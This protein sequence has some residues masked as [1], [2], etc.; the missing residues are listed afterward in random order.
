MPDTAPPIAAL[1]ALIASGEVDPATVM[2]EAQKNADKHPGNGNTYLHRDSA[3]AIREALALPAKFPEA[4]DRPPLYGI[5]V[6]VKDCFDIIGTVATCGSKFYEAHNPP[7]L[8]NAW[9]VDRLLAAGAVITGKTH[10]H[11][12]AYG[13]TGENPEYGDCL[14][15]RDPSLLTGG[16]SSGAVASVQEGSA[17]FA[18][19]TDTGGSVRV[20][21]ALC[22]LAG[23]RASL[24][25]FPETI[26]W[27]GGAHL[28]ESFDTLGLLFHDLRDAPLLGEAVFAIARV[29]T[30]GNPR[31]GIPTADFLYDCDPDVLAAF[32]AWQHRL[33]EHGATIETFETTTWQDCKEIFTTIQAS[34]ASR[35]HRGHF[36]EFEPSIAERLTWGETITPAQLA[37]LHQRLEAFRATIDELFTRFDFLLLPCAPVSRLVAGDD[38]SG[39]RARILRY[40]CPISMAGLPTV[41]LAGELLATSH[42]EHFGTGMQLCAPRLKDAEL[43]AFAA[44]L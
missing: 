43:L 5:P 17:M 20:P 10:L 11:P 8:T 36:S 33:T 13:I 23:Y 35:Y 42:G 12:L 6:S 26:C 34:E 32:T 16:S 38:Q 21:A 18:I 25:L 39:A 40:T 2:I 27:Q 31:I 37:A 7:A 28:A 9:I 15:P 19:G 29:P 4:D 24:G 3:L 44:A 22:G 1:R 14:Q 41:T 30:P